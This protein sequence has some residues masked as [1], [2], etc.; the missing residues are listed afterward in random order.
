MAFESL[1]WSD[2]VGGL[3]KRIQ[4]EGFITRKR[5]SSREVHRKRFIQRSSS[6]GS[7]W[8]FVNDAPRDSSGVQTLDKY[9]KEISFKVIRVEDLMAVV[10]CF[11]RDPFAGFLWSRGSGDSQFKIRLSELVSRVWAVEL[12]ELLVDCSWITSDKLMRL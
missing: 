6:K 8:R 11:Q 9:A 4:L 1:L 10:W 7:C 2:S 3:S 5:D 12:M